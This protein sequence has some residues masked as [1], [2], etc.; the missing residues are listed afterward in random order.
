MDT[1]DRHAQ[2]SYVPYHNHLSHPLTGLTPFEQAAYDIQHTPKNRVSGPELG[3]T[4]PIDETTIDKQYL[5]I[6][7]CLTLFVILLIVV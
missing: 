4:A 5:L 2:H 6:A 7:V 1:I 3:A